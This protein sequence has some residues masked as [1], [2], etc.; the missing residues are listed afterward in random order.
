MTHRRCDSRCLNALPSSPCSCAC[1]GR[2]HAQG[3][4]WPAE[5]PRRRTIP[6]VAGPS[7]MKQHEE[8][9]EQLTLL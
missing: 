9:A 8:N 2:N 1:G 4:V 5:D 6:T 7:R 3:H